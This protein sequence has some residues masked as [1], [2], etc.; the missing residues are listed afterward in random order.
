MKKGDKFIPLSINQTANTITFGTQNL[1]KQS[2]NSVKKSV[3]DL[4]IENLTEI[5]KV[6]LQPSEGIIRLLG[7]LGYVSAVEGY[8]RQLFREIILFDQRSNNKCLS[9]S[10]SFGAALAVSKEKKA[11]NYLPE[12]MLE[13]ITFASKT[14][15]LAAFKEYLDIK[16]NFPDELDKALEDFEKICHLRHCAVHRFGKLGAHNAIA[17]G[18]DEHSNKI[19]FN[20]SLELQDLENIAVVCLNLIKVVNNFLFNKLLER[21]ADD[22]YVWTGDYSKDK[23]LFKKYCSIFKP[24]NVSIKTNKKYKALYTQFIRNYYAN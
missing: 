4:F 23:K 6:V 9:Q 24:M 3:I 18:F 21:T 10:I 22:S 8:F 2:S 19:G 15:I 16:G 5:N 14:Q 1:F 7:L 17:L 13:K 20:I 11:M 12:A